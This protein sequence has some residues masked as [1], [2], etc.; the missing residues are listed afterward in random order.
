M[1][2]VIQRVT[3]AQV[4]VDGGE[5]RTIGQGFVVLLGVGEAD[6]R[7]EADKLWNKICKLRIFADDEGKTNRAL[8]DV[9]GELLIV[10]QFTLYADCRK[11]NRPSF[12]HAGAP[13]VAIPLYEYFVDLARAQVP[14]VETGEFGADMQITLCNDGPFTICLDTDDL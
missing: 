14:H 10:S 13:D 3:Q 9:G 4:V 11:G 7:A 5:P 2:A 6:T 8:A 1:K 12:V